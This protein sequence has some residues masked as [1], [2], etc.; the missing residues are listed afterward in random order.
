MAFKEADTNQDDVLTGT[1]LA[2]YIFNKID[3]SGNGMIEIGEASAALEAA[4]NYTTLPLH[5][6]YQENLFN[7][8]TALGGGLMRRGDGHSFD[9]L[10]AQYND[11]NFPTSLDTL[12]VI[13]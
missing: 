3:T 10:V 8:F 6:N 11:D 4:S 2:R 9:H 5:P 13:P 1:E 7:M 12:L